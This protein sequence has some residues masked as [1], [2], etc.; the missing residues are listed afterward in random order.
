MVLSSKY[1]DDGVS[2][3]TLSKEQLEIRDQIDAKLRNRE[4]DLRNNSCLCG[5]DKAILL[6]EKDCFGLPQKVLLCKKCS[7]I[8]QNP[9]FLNYS[10]MFV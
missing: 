7:L 8:Y 2:F 10:R 9:I 3:R 5:S 4:Y 1:K 6:A